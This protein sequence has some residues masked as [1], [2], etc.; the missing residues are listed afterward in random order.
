MGEAKISIIGAGSFFTNN[1]IKDIMLASEPS[2]GVFALVDTDEDRL[3]LA[4]KIAQ[5]VVDNF[6]G[7]WKI[8]SHTERTEIIQDSDFLI[9]TIEVSGLDTVEYDYEIPKKYGVDQCIGDTTGPG[10]LMKGLRTIPSWIEILKDAENLCPNAL[11]LNY[12]NPMNMMT[13]IAN[14]ISNLAIVGLC[15]SAQRTS[16]DLANYLKIP[17][18]KLEWECAG[19]NHMSWFTKLACEGRALYPALKKKA[20]DPEFY[21]RD[22]IRFEMMLQLG[23]FVTE[24]S[25]H[26]SEYLPYFRKREELIDRYCRE[27][28]KGESGFYA[29]NWP[30]WRKAMDLYRKKWVKNEDIPSNVLEKVPGKGIDLSSRS[31]EYGSYI[32]ESHFKEKPFKFYGNFPNNGL[33]D[34]LPGHGIVEVQSLADQN[35]FQPCKFGKLPEQLAA[36]NRPH[37]SLH[38]MAVESILEEDREK[39]I[40]ALMLDPLTSA[41][42]SPQEIREM[43]EELFQAE[44][45]YLPEFIIS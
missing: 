22:P 23:Y 9:N 8:R 39:S 12:T 1:W 35:G 43:A 28:Y 11:V 45:D 26:F 10:G 31:H 19:I 3:R 34:N 15:H 5:K 2:K 6:D 37:L 24:S 4:H 13:L 42:C 38:K 33:I 29:R 27:G 7:N 30:K 20:L 16:R 21:K 18:E 40:R 44:A 41:A 36:L 25:G 14:K 17:Y 32:I